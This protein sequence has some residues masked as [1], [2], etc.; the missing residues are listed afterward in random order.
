MANNKRN[1]TWFFYYKYFLIEF[2]VTWQTSKFTTSALA[3]AMP[4][5]VRI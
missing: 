5:T 2:R 4:T 3:N 1:F